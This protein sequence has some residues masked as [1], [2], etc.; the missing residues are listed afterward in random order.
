MRAVLS[1]PRPAFL[2]PL[3]LAAAI[4][5]VGGYAAVQ[6]RHLAERVAGGASGL[7]FL[8][9]T[10][11]ARLGLEHGWAAVYDRHLYGQYAH[12]GGPVSFANLP[13][14]AWAAVP[15]AGLPFRAGLLA[16]LAAL[17]ALLLVAWAVTA[18]GGGWQRLAL[19]GVLLTVT[20]VLRALDVGQFTLA[21]ASLLALHWWLVQRGRPVLAGVA[22]ALACLKPQVV[23][24]VPAALALTGRWRCL[25]AWAAAAGLLALA[26]AAALGPAGVLAYRDGLAFTVNPVTTAATLWRVVPGWVPA[27]PLRAAIL[28]LALAPALCEGRPRY[29]RAVAGA[30]LGSVLTTPYLIGHDLTSLAVAGFLVLGTDPPPWARWAMLPSYVALAT[31]L[32]ALWLGVELLWLPLL[33]LV[34]LVPWLVQPPA[35]PGPAGTGQP[36]R[37]TRHTRTANST[38]TSASTA[39]RTA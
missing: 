9:A 14:V 36:R 8:V 18:P 31:P 5:V 2:P 10:A 30:V 25:A 12:W 29:G 39:A 23:F 35:A 32:A 21:V 38:I 15:F 11:A 19:L 16:W 33:A 24:L 13:A 34:A 1:R 6:L 22:L 20:P 3:P 27:L 4:V 37:S 28:V 7:D 26:M 17:T